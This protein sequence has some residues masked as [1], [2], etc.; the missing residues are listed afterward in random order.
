MPNISDSDFDAFLTSGNHLASALI[1]I[2]GAAESTFP[3]Y[4]CPPDTA[5]GI[6]KDP[7]KWDLWMAWRGGML[8]RDKYRP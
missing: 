3:P 1:H 8:L 2:L 4:T 7:I 6:I 5:L